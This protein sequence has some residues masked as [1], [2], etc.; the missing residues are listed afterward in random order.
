[1]LVTK[2]SVTSA[3]VA[4][5]E[6]ATKNLVWILLSLHL[7]ACTTSLIH[8]TSS[9]CNAFRLTPVHSTLRTS[10]VLAFSPS[11]GTKAIVLPK[12][13]TGPQD[14]IVLNGFDKWSG[15]EVEIGF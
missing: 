12:K 13:P 5:C 3:I 14:V 4:F 11:F 2:M 7:C 1:M 6:D 8:H 9:A 10:A 15:K